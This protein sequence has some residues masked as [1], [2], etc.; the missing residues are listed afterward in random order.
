MEHFVYLELVEDFSE[1][2]GVNDHDLDDTLKYMTLF[3]FAP[4]SC[5]GTFLSAI[6]LDGTA[7]LIGRFGLR[8][9]IYEMYPEEISLSDD[10]P[11]A[12][13]VKRR[14]F[15]WLDGYPSWHG[16]L[17]G[18][19]LD[20]PIDEIKGFIS[21]PIERNHSPIATL[22][23]VCTEQIDRNAEV[24]AFLKAIGSIFSSFFNKT[25]NGGR[26]VQKDRH[27]LNS[28]RLVFEGRKLTERQEQIL[29]LM[30]EGKTNLAISQILGFSES[31]IRQESIRIY[32]KLRCDGR[33]EAALI[34]NEL[35]NEVA[36]S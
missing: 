21:W 29:Q 36:A 5:I 15:I 17:D 26:E 13:A 23:I 7:E 32:E 28:A 19:A 12:E 20:A 25:S 16:D 11:I 8:R 9:N 27:L 1:Y 24:S 22:S 14:T 30:S 4:L 18:K 3:T 34:Y 35:K 2:L 33:K 10:N 31:T 6:N